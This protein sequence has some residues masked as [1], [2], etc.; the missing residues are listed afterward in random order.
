MTLALRCSSYQPIRPGRVQ[1][2]ASALLA[3]AIS[4]GTNAQAS[5]LHPRLGSMANCSSTMRCLLL[6]H[7]NCCVAARL[8]GGNERKRALRSVGA[9]SS[10][11]VRNG[12]SSRTRRIHRR[13]RVSVSTSVHR[14]CILRENRAWSVA[15]ASMPPRIVKGH[16]KKEPMYI[17]I[18]VAF[19]LLCKARWR[20]LDK[21]SR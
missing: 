3:N 9:P 12:C 2:N 11:K 17:S 20:R 13:E 7:R 16:K 19:G 21:V 15:T 8:V 6:V 4:M 1:S 14:V 5:L 10:R 18:N